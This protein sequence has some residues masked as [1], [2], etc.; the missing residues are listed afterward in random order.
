MK[1]FSFGDKKFYTIKHFE[2]KFSRT[3]MKVRFY[4]VISF[5]SK[6][7]QFLIREKAKAISDKVK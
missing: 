2:K 7:K 1:K 5:W 6:T 3:E 4:I